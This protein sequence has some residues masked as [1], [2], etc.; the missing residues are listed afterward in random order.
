M[1]IYRDIWQGA[2]LTYLPLKEENIKTIGTKSM[3]LV[4]SN[5]IGIPLVAILQG[6]I[7]L[8]GYYIFGVENPFFWFVITTIGSVIPFVGTA[9]GILPVCLILLSQGET[10]SAIGM[11][12]YGITVVGST[13]NLFRLIVQR[14][15]ADIHPLIT[16]IGVLVG[17]PLFG[18]IGL[19]FGPLL[20]SSLLLLIKIYKDEYVSNPENI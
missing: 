13:D 5:A 17:V 20:I 10:G 7:A 8:I 19:V 18:F 1:L 9:I 14:K 11:L 12:I 15:L 6:V 16:L 4:R 3:G 2:A